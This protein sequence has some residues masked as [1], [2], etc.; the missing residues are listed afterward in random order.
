[1]NLYCCMIDLKQDAKALAFAAALDAW[2]SHLQTHGAIG[3][4]RLYRSKL[5]LS[6]DAYRD[7]LLEIEVEDLSHL[8]RAFRLTGKHDDETAQLHD[9][10]HSQIARADFAL[11]RPY[12][13][14]ERA[15]RMALV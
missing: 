5:N 7:F 15:E 8:D 13:D 1:M 14:P 10:V 2:M 9:R 6:A 3:K 4:W 12:P 11:Y